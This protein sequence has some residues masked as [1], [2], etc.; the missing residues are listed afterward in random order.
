[1]PPRGNVS[2]IVDGRGRASGRGPGR[3]A[4]R[5]NGRGNAGGRGG[6]GGRG[7]AGG[8]RRGGR[9]GRGSNN[10]T[11]SKETDLDEGLDECE[12]PLRKAGRWRKRRWRCKRCCR[13]RGTGREDA[14]GA[15]ACPLG[16]LPCLVF[17]F[18]VLL[19][20]AVDGRGL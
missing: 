15:V 14:K 6:R 10:F 19:F 11:A 7:G 9:G 1:M 12:Q 8:G 13:R 16:S 4:G 3:G 2:Q 5:T 20:I 17:S 18:G